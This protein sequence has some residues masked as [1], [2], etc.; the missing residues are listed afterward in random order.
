[1]TRADKPAL[2][3]LPK[4][5]KWAADIMT[6]A[7][8]QSLRQHIQQQIDAAVAQARADERRKALEEAAT[9]MENTGKRIAASDIRAL[10]DK[11]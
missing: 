2:P 10:I 4:L 6:T 5:P 3:A 9:L 8:R 1:M 7:E 11:E